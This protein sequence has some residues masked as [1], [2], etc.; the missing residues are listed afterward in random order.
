[1]LPMIVG[2]DPAPEVH[3]ASDTGMEVSDPAPADA[4]AETGMILDE[5]IGRKAQDDAS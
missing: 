5:N 3:D 4:T 1:M 2:S